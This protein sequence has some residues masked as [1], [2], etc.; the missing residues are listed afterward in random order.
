MWVLIFFGYFLLF[1]ILLDNVMIVCLPVVLHM[2]IKVD[3]PMFVLEVFVDYV[4]VMTKSAPKTEDVGIVM[5]EN[6]L[7]H[8]HLFVVVAAN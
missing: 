7:L 3:K 5:V 4:V 2:P 6:V 1:K 8:L